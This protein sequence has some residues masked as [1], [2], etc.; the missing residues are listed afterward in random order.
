MARRTKKRLGKDAKVSVLA[1]YLHPS[2]LISSTLPNIENNYRLEDC[3]VVRMVMKKVNRRD[4]L[5][6]VMKHDSFKT[7]DGAYEDI[8]T[9]PRWCKVTEEGPSEAYFHVGDNGQAILQEASNENTVEDEDVELP[10]IIA[11]I[12]HRGFRDDDIL[13]MNGQ[14]EVDDDNLPAPENVPIEDDANGV[15]DVFVEWGHDGVCQR[16]QAGGQNAS[17]SLFNF[18]GHAGVPSILQTFEILFPKGFLESVVIK[19][20]NKKL[21]KKMSC[22]EFYVWI[23]LWFFMGTTYF[24]DRREF[25][26]TK[27]ID[28]FQG[29]PFRFNDFMSRNRFENILAALTLTNQRAPIYT[30]RFWEVRQLIGEW[31]SN[32][33]MKFFPSWISCLDESMSKWVGKYSCP[34]FMCVPRKPW[35]LGN[36]YHTIAC[37]TSGVLYQMELVEGRDTPKRAPPKEYSEMGKTVGLLLRLTKPIWG[38]SRV[39]VLDSGFCVLK[40]IVELRKKGVFATALV[41]KRRYWPKYVKGEAIKQYFS[42]KDIGT[43]DAMKGVLDSVKVELHCLKE[44]DYTMTLMSSYGTLEKVGEDKVR[45]YDEGNTTVEKNIKYP[46]LIYNHFSYRDAVDSHNSSRMFPIAME[47]TWK[48]TRWPLRVFCFLLAV[49]EVNC[50]L[51]LTNIYN[52]SEMSQQDFRKE[53]SREFLHNKYLCLPKPTKMRKSKR[54]NDPDHCLVSLPK[55]R[56]FKKTTLVYCK[57]TYIQLVCSFCGSCKVRTYCPCSPGKIICTA[58]FADHVRLLET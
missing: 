58:C 38:S 31:N 5:V 48:T 26:S 57:T 7:H 18:G 14:V 43:V 12:E 8:Y 6:V 54:L 10:A 52:Q 41:K 37:G 47:E 11:Q 53:L 50:R 1:R 45:I 19:E 56:T 40:G 9:V 2:R 16:R 46:E 33:K 49:T 23:G 32:M 27:A 20:T 22:G 30:D 21:D 24:G 17:A 44:P 25:W 34:G 35:P 3:I 4:Q 42:T 28:A 15:D 55:N 13:Q 29:T 36:E 51:V 39:V